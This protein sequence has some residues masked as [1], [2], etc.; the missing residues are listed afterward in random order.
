MEKDKG[1]ANV[2]CFDCCFH[3]DAFQPAAQST[4]QYQNSL[5][6]TAME[7]VEEAYKRQNQQVVGGKKRIRMSVV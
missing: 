6:L 7:G 3:P 4:A 5:V 1:G 2:P